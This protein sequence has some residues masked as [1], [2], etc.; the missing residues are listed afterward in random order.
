MIKEYITL[1][2]TKITE[3]QALEWHEFK[4]NYIDGISMTVK[5]EQ[6]FI[7]QELDSIR[8]MMNNE[9]N[10]TAVFNDLKNRCS[11]FEIL[12]IE[13]TGNYIVET[14]SLFSLAVSQLPLRS[15]AVFHRNDPRHFICLQTLDPESLAPVLEETKKYRYSI[16]ED[17]EIYA[18][19]EFLYNKAGLL[20]TAID[21]TSDPENQQNWKYYDDSDFQDLQDRFTI[22]ISYYRSADLLPE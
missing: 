20:E 16:D 8:Y 9:E 19:I 7:S 22:D 18:G 21:K 12:S 14:A 2:G 15:K 4:I 5:E 6:H 10:E 1:S 17:G 11:Q 3:Q 13:V